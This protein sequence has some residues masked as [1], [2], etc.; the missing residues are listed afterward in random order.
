[1]ME[2]GELPIHDVQAR[3]N[4]SGGVDF[5]R[6]EIGRTKNNAHGAGLYDSVKEKGLQQGDVRNIDLKEITTLVDPVSGEKRQSEGHHRI[7]AAAAVEQETG[8]TQW[9]RPSY[10]PYSLTPRDTA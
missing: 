9:I 5:K 2:P 7:A 4:P 10:K 1:M 8:K 3:T 6:V